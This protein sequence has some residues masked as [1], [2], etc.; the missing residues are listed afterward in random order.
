MFSHKSSKSSKDAFL[1][2][3]MQLSRRLASFYELKKR[4][5]SVTSSS[6]SFQH[7]RPL[8][9]SSSASMIDA[10]EI[11]NHGT[12]QKHEHPIRLAI[13]DPLFVNSVKRLEVDIRERIVELF[14]QTK[15]KVA[16]VPAELEQKDREADGNF[17]K[18]L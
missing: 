7:R 17:I 11:Q 6:P 2:W 10:Q 12:N 9:R 15:N 16:V 8:T 13:F 18:S 4:F 5:L 3:S 14:G 1:L